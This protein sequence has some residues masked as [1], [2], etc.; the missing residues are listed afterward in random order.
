M[1]NDPIYCESC[2]SEF[3][4]V[5][6]NEANAI[7]IV[8]CPYCGFEVEPSSDDEDYVDEEF[9]DEEDED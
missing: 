6:V 5:P 8:F 7:E 1:D 2:D 9:G 3:I 4:V